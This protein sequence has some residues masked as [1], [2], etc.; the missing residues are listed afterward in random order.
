MMKIF[1]K[2]YVGVRNDEDRLAFAVP[3]DNTSA[4]AK[5]KHTVDEWTKGSRYN[6]TIPEFLT[7]DN[8]PKTGFE[9]GECVTRHVTSNRLFRVLDPDY[10]FQ[11]EI[12]SDNLASILKN[13]TIIKGVIQEKCLWARDGAQ[14]CLVLENDPNCVRATDIANAKKTLTPGD[15]FLRN[16]RKCVYLGVQE[17]STITHEYLHRQHWQPLQA[18]I[19]QE[20]VSSHIYIDIEHKE[21]TRVK[22]KPSAPVISKMGNHETLIKKG[23]VYSSDSYSTKIVFETKSLDADFLVKAKNF[24]N[25]NLY[26]FEYINTK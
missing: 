19:I 5:R 6:K 3:I 4:Y 26:S 10:K 25:V 24:G 14:N 11:V 16:R 7:I 12:S 21:I 15:V 9:V 23:V 22:N 20:V 8:T 13:C 2:L 17:F 18:K 1:D